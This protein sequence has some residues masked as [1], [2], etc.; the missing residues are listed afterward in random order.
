[1]TLLGFSAGG[2]ITAELL[3]R[4]RDAPQ[5]DAA[6]FVYTPTVGGGGHGFGVDPTDLPVGRR[7]ELFLAWLAQP[8]R[9]GS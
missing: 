7:P 2:R 6:A 8:S 5:P 3:L 4:R 9:L 1:M